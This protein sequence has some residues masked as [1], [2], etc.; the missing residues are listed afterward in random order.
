MPARVTPQASSCDPPVIP[1]A[2]SDLPI[3]CCTPTEEEIN[4]AIKQLKNGIFAGP[5]SIPAEAY[6]ADVETSVALLHPLFSKI[7]EE[8]EN[9]SEWK[10]GYLI[11]LRKKGDLSSCSNYREISLLSIPGKLFNRILLNR[12]KDAMQERINMVANNSGRL[13]LT[14]KRGQPVRNGCSHQ[15]PHRNILKIRLPDKISN[16]ELWRRTKQQ[17]FEADILQRCWRWIDHTLRKPASNATMQSLTWNPQGK[18][19]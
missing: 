11:K 6:K 2:I 17:Q 9:P 3:K 18:R 1:P 13:G 19:K 16:E 4:S 8:T 5:N 7:W 12:M 15:N 10:E 14:I